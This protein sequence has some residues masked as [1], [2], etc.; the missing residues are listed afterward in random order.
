MG[1]SRRQI[2]ITT[3]IL[4]VTVLTACG[5]S[6]DSS[7]GADQQASQTASSATQTAGTESQTANSASPTASPE[8]TADSTQS[9]D[10]EALSENF[11]AADSLA[12]AQEVS[13]DSPDVQTVQER[14]GDVQKVLADIEPLAT[15]E[16]PGDTDSENAEEE[17][18]DETPQYVSDESVARLEAVA[19]DSALDQYI[20][21]ATEYAMNGWRVEGAPA[22][23]GTPKVADGEYKSQQAK[24]LEVC[25]DSSE[26]KVL[27]PKGKQINSSQS[28]RSLNIFT[29]IENNGEWKIASQDFPNNADC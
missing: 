16:A 1:N 10:Q 27:D 3:G 15:P 28:T 19:T 23:V 29:L 22:V 24:I 26:V 20:A 5:G 21:T 11:A 8:H 6:A 12:T 18:N 9:A 2:L 17:Q 7:A 25:L 4:G 13:L 14:Y